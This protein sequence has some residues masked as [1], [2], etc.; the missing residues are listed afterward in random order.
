MTLNAKFNKM[1]LL[2]IPNMNSIVERKN[3]TFQIRQ[4]VADDYGTEN[5]TDDAGRAQEEDFASY[6]T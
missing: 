2:E 4:I 6:Y 5:Y 3:P 1:K